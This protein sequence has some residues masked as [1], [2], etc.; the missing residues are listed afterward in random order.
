ME[1]EYYKILIAVPQEK[2]A[3]DITQKL[4]EKKLIACGFIT[5]GLS[6]HWWKGKIDKENYWSIRVYSIM[7]NKDKIIE[8]VKEISSEE[9]PGITFFKIDDGNQDFF[10]WI[11]ES[12]KNV[13]Q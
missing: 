6:M 1:K 5:K 13:K 11:E 8:V 9:V 12:I 10:D 4:L 7:E 2:E 3:Q